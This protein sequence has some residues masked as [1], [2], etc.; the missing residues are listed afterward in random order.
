VWD[1]PAIVKT[2]KATH[3]TKAVIHGLRCGLGLRL[4]LMTDVLQKKRFIQLS[5]RTGFAA[6]PPAREVQQVIAIGPK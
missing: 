1:I 2:V 4:K 6:A 5:Q 3:H